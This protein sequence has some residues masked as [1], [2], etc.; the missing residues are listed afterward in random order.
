MKIWLLVNLVTKKNKT[1]F[2]CDLDLIGD[3]LVKYDLLTNNDK[4]C[5]RGFLNDRHKK[6]GWATG[7]FMNLN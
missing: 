4:D 6:T 5:Y 2:V 7:F 3:Q 1:F